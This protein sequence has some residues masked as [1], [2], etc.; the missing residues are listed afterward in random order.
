VDALLR[1]M[2]S[3][4]RVDQGRPG[5]SP[6]VL[7]N[8]PSDRDGY[9]GFRRV[10]AHLSSIQDRHALF[11]EHLVLHYRWTLPAGAVTPESFQSLQTGGFTVN[12]DEHDGSYQVFRR[13]NGRVLISNYDP[14][15]L[16]DEERTRVHDEAEAGSLNDILVDVRPDHPG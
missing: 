10:V 9:I 6:T 3:E 16:S 1:L 11:A 15:G 13:V 8:S 14:A 4:F 2:V 12:H 7:N 5:Q